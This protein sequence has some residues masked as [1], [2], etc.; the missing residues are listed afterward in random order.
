VQD[1]PVTV[2][3][4]AP[5]EAD[6]SALVALHGMGMSP[7]A[8]A[9][10]VLALL[11]AG[12]AAVL[13]QAPLPFELRGAQGRRQGNAWYVYTGDSEAFLRAMERT[14]RWLLE[15]VAACVAEHGLDPARVALLGFSQ[16]GYLAG[17]VG[18]RH[19]DRFRRVVVAGARLK[20]EAFLGAGA[21]LGDNAS[22][23]EGGAPS[24][25]AAAR[26]ADW[27]RGPEVLCMH[28]DHDPSVPVTAARESPTALP[29]A[30]LRVTFR[31]YPTAH[32]V[33]RDPGCRA[34]VR[35]FLA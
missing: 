4:P 15:V 32:A 28:G 3:L 7:A 34:A 18:L 17:F 6:G 19:G 9:P 20:H 14:E 30:G 5:A 27:G 23:A 22:R 33:L 1:V 25:V 8:F 26:P 21:A 35:T 29:A 12:T 16:G 24:A 10:D 13:P 2:R 31:T 11:P